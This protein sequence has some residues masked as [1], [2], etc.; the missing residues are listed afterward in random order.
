VLISCLAYFST[1]KM[2]VTFSSEMSVDFLQSTWRYTPDDRPLVLE[3]PSV[4]FPANV[5]MRKFNC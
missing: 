2:E 4:Y 3:R 5:E 1:L